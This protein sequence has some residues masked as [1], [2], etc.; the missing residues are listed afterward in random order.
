MIRY[1]LSEIKTEIDAPMNTLPDVI[2]RMMGLKPSDITWWEI[3]RKSV[4][5]RKKPHILYV[6]TAD[7]IADHPIKRASR[8]RGLTVIDPES[9]KVTP[10][11]PG[12]EK[13]SGRPV[14]IGMGPAGLFA[15]LE[16]A[17]NGYRPIVLERG[18]LRQDI[19]DGKF[20]SPGCFF[21]K[22]GFGRSVGARRCFL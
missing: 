3:R 10:P 4:D 18:Q 2:A 17:A 8:I 5:S 21:R 16:L 20:S 7:F 9:E 6:Y 11:E 13:L 19:R 1:R 22:C 15:G 12:T 14:V